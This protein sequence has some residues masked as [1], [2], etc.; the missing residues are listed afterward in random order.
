MHSP[1]KNKMIL[2]RPARP[3][4]RTYAR[5]P[6]RPPTLALS[7]PGRLQPRT[8]P[9]SMRP[10][11]LQPPILSVASGIH[12]AWKASMY[13]DLANNNKRQRALS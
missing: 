4:A 5:P 8:L 9:A 13:Q 2:A 3:H 12:G 7:A 11:R 10:T 6:A 1:I